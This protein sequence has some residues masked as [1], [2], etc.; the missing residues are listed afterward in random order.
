MLS[1]LNSGRLGENQHQRDGEV[2]E[3]TRTLSP[4]LAQD[5]KACPHIGNKHYSYSANL[6]VSQKVR[7]AGDTSSCIK[8]TC[9]FLGSVV[10]GTF[11]CRKSETNSRELDVEI[12][13]SVKQDAEST[14]SDTIVQMYKVR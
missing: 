12:H 4:V 3:W 5:H 14:A 7:T 8:L 10:H 11:H 13:Y 2:W 9:C 1:W 6:S